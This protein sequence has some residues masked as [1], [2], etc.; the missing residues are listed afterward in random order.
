MHEHS[1]EI[2]NPK[3]GKPVSK[4]NICAVAETENKSKNPEIAVTQNGKFIL[5]DD[6]DTYTECKNQKLIVKRNHSRYPDLEWIELNITAN[7]KRLHP[8]W[9]NKI[10]VSNFDIQMFPQLWGSTAGGFEAP[11]MVAGAAMTT[12]YTTVIRL[13]IYMLDEENITVY[14]VYFGNRPAYLVENANE[15]FLTD[16]QNKNLK[17]KYEAEKYY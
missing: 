12:E 15:T 6:N 3:D 10:H 7:I 8:E 11:G 13:T 17:S 1:F 4:E 2:I 14:G 16:L 5:L 9:S